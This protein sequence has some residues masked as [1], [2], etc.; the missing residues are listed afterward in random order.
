MS[1]VG[2]GHVFTGFLFLVRTFG[3]RSR[4]TTGC[5]FGRHFAAHPDHDG[6]LGVVRALAVL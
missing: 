6:F 1:D 3:V 4:I 2:A 5:G